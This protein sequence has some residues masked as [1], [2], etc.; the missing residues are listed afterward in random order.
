MEKK[1]R[2]LSNHAYL[3]GT[4]ARTEK[5]YIPVLLIYVV[6]QFAM[7]FILIIPPRYIV[8]GLAEGKTITEVCP[9]IAVMGGLYLTAHL[10]AKG[11]FTVKSNLELRLKVRLNV[12]MGDKCMHLDYETFESGDVI[13]TIN[14]ARLAVNGGLT[15][16]QSISLSGSQGIGGYFTQLGNLAADI[17][18]IAGM[19]YVLNE[20]KA[21]VIAVMLVGMA[22]NIICCYE[23]KRTNVVLRDYSAPFLRKNRYCNRVL[24]SVEAGKD[25]RLYDLE[26]YLLDKFS[27]CN[28]NYIKAKNQYR[29]RQVMADIISSVCGGCVTFTVF[30]SLILLMNTGTITIGGFVMISGAVVS[31]FGCGIAMV[32]ELMELDIHL[33][34]MTDYRKLM[35]YKT[36]PGNAGRKISPGAHAIRFEDVSFS[37][38]NSVSY[39]N[40]GSYGNAGS[41]GG[42]ERKALEHVNVT[43]PAGEIV[44]IVG[45]N[46]AGKS[47]FVKLLTGLYRPTEGQIYIDDIPIGE[48]DRD[49]LTDYIAVLFQDFNTYS[50]TVEENVTLAEGKDSEKLEKSLAESGA[51]ERIKR[52]KEGTGTFV[53][54]I[55]GNGGESLSGGEEQKLALARVF[56]KNADLLILDVKYSIVLIV[57]GV[58]RVREKLKIGTTYTNRKKNVYDVTWKRIRKILKSGIGSG[59][60]FMP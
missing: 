49:S 19:L 56:Y 10:L 24:R 20:L 38:G 15:F 55:F 48:I 21:W 58:Y 17:M 51:L 35:E 44:S 22:V 26:D 31:L 9:M 25:I 41:H 4:V 33:T 12:A 13:D 32:S 1:V 36:A 28:E 46:G 50:M 16:A 14:S 42:S 2:T 23:K 39:G 5:L 54:D 45:M 59:S 7:P 6:L 18:K 3:L 37:Y 29:N 40:T 52:M 34:Y 30:F 53:R 60:F 57:Y 11:I 8:D 43:I 47:T 27:E